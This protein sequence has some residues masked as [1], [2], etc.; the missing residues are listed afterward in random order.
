MKFLHY[1]IAR[2]P[3]PA[4]WRADRGDAAPEKDSDDEE[5]SRIYQHLS[6][7]ATSMRVRMLLRRRKATTRRCVC[8]HTPVFVS[9]NCYILCVRIYVCPHTTKEKPS[10]ED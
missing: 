6:P 5:V 3:L 2:A 9:A 8:P 7:Y 10:D 1:V 4:T